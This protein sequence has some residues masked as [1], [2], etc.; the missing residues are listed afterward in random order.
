MNN[1]P[2][3][4]FFLFLILYLVTFISCDGPASDRVSHKKCKEEEKSMAYT[5]LLLM[6]DLKRNNT[7]E[8]VF[9]DISL[10][11]YTRYD[12][13]LERWRI[14][15][16]IIDPIDNLLWNGCGRCYK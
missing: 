12:G 8:P 1:L 11:F 4:L 6:E 3:S 7:T 15:P 2:K 16:K 14:S 9:N 13:C 10:I 5:L